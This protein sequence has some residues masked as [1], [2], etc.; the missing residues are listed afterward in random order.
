MFSRLPSSSSALALGSLLWASS[1]CAQTVDPTQDAKGNVPVAPAKESNAQETVARSKDALVESKGA[2]IYRESCAECHGKRGEGVMGKYDD[3]LAGNRSL[4]SLVRVI[5]K[6][7]PEGK[8]G[9]CIGPDAEAVAAFIFD[10]FY[11]P[12]AQARLRPV[13]ESLS[14]LTVS[15]FQNS[16]ADLLGRFR[17]GFDTALGN[18]RGLRGVYSGFAF[19]TPEEE[20]ENRELAAK[21]KDKKPPRP[22]K[23]ERVDPL[24][25][26]QFGPGS[27][28]PEKMTPESFNV[29]WNGSIFAS[30]TGT[31]EF[32]V[33]TQN[34]VRLWVNEPKEP[35]IDSWVTPGPE[36]R[37]V[38]KTIFLLGGRCYRISLAMLKFKDKS[39]S[40]ELMWKPPFGTLETVPSAVLMPQEINTNVIVKTALPADDRS[41]GYER[42]TAVSKEWDAAVTAAALEV[43]AHVETTLDELTGSKSANPDRVDKLKRFCRTFVEAAFRRPITDEQ[44]AN[45]IE[46]VFQASP[47]PVIAVKRL[48]LYT[49]KS[50]RFLYPELAAD[51]ASDDFA[52]ASRLALVLWDSLPD[53]TLWKAATEG[54]LRTQ[55]EIGQ[56]VR[57]MVANPRA[58]A[59]LHGF[60]Q[61]WLDLERA[62]HAAKDNALFPE[63][64]DALRADLRK[65]LFL[66][67]D[68]VAWGDQ[69]DYRRLFQ[70]DYLWLNQRLGRVYGKT[71]ESNDFQRV[72]LTRGKRA[73]VLTHPYLLSALSYSRT[74]SPVHRGVFLS[75]SVVGIQ[76]KNPSVAVAF[77]DAKFDPKLTMREKVTSLTK[78]ASC[79]GCHS[80][81]NPLGFTLENYDA[82]GRWRTEENR[83]AV[84]T[85]VDF[86]AEEG[87][88]LHFSNA[89]DV[90][91]HAAAS[92]HAHEAFVR[93][94]FLY[95]VKQPP[96]AFGQDT[97]ERLR[98]Q[99]ATNGFDIRQL[100]AQIALTKAVPT[101]PEPPKVASQ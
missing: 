55:E 8:E 92:V 46:R 56:Q 42:G 41:D 23:F 1:A 27:P 59:K 82:I 3:P 34:G 73:G 78:N 11:S 70:A 80:V 14:R 9:T 72:T 58:K 75:R 17:P 81:I 24:I 68:E 60:F 26:V 79:A 74:T 7:M 47:T 12:T 19:P 93:Q 91:N 4:P 44:N 50:P 85:L 15:Q 36:I 57:R 88:S 86:D 51:G 90:A 66:F 6:T 31:Y 40:V 67:L 63:F 83:K 29:R 30:E 48:V 84:D 21:N 69:P 52:I 100:L 43:V 45:L 97:L 89:Q 64:D 18:Q 99:F 10:A 33:K 2:V 22:E 53:A 38:R 37:E 54:K 77:E 5:S 65:S 49:L 76:L 94:M 87:V 96:A 28:D 25:A 20:A 32:V 61:Q 101:S 13:Q 62:E 95:T 16:V 98:T 39:A 71:L 35:L